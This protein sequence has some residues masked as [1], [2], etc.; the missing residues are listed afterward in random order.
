MYAIRS[1]YDHDV[2]TRFLESYPPY[3]GKYHANEK[4]IELAKKACDKNNINYFV[5]RIVSGE[6]FISDTA[7]KGKIIDDFTPHAVRITSYNVC[8]TKLLRLSEIQRIVAN[9]ISFL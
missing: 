9:G 8:Y 1:Y 6:Q 3:C 5:G 2:T 4:L 7:V